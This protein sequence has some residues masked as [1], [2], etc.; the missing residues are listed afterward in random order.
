MGD[1]EAA[2]KVDRRRVYQVWPGNNVR[3][4]LGFRRGPAC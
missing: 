3:T 2:D 4:L 1:I